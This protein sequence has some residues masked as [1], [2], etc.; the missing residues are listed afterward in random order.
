[1]YCLS[2][3]RHRVSSDI[4]PTLYFSVTP[5]YKQWDDQTAR[6]I[7]IVHSPQQLNQYAYIFWQMCFDVYSIIII[8][9]I[10]MCVTSQL[11]CC[12]SD[13]K[14][15]TTLCVYKL[16]CLPVDGKYRL[17]CYRLLAVLGVMNSTAE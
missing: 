5:Q 17:T 12:V 8:I 16:L 1:M 7:A 2:V 15:S 10:I 9:I 14:V 11:I 13:V 4:C 3:I 6:T